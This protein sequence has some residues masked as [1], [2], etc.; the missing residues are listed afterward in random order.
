LAVA[1]FEEVG[2][3]VECCR[4][5]RVAEAAA[6][7]ADWHAGGEQLGG[8]EVSKVVQAH[9][10]EV[11]LLAHPGESLRECTSTG[12]FAEPRRGFEPLTYA[13]RVR[14]STD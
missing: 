11:G 9:A 3:D 4:G 8:V 12:C 10:V 6:D 13:L 14:C 1:C 5:V 2:V 7:G